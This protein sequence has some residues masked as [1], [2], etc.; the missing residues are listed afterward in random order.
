MKANNKK[1]PEHPHIKKVIQ[2]NDTVPNQFGPNAYPYY[3]VLSE[4]TSNTYSSMDFKFNREYF[5]IKYMLSGRGLVLEGKNRY[6]VCPGAIV[7]MKFPSDKYEFIKDPECPEP[8]KGMYFE[9]HAGALEPML[10]DMNDKY[11]IIYSQNRSVDIGKKMFEFNR[12]WDSSP[13]DRLGRCRFHLS[14]IE[15]NS[16]IFLLLSSIDHFKGRTMSLNNKLINS[17]CSY[18]S[19]HLDTELKI[20][21]LAKRFNISRGHL[22]RLFKQHLKTSPNKYIRITRISRACDMIMNTNLTNS[23]IAAHIGID[24]P[25]QYY[26]LFKQVAGLTPGE[27]KKSDIKL[28]IMK[29]LR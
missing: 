11:G 17:V 9:F 27:F 13:I 29:S 18:I 5:I 20:N 3:W 21:D 6:P 2:F 15:A 1:H 8:W 26:R 14:P 25:V 28:E 10:D 22:T 16:L 7:M 23:E 12:I 19:T 4:I 24:S